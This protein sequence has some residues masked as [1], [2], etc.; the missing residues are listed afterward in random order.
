M[1]KLKELYKQTSDIIKYVPTYCDELRE[2]FRKCTELYM[3]LNT[4]ADLSDSNVA[5]ELDST[6]KKIAFASAEPNFDVRKEYLKEAITDL[7][8][9]RDTADVLC[10][11]DNILYVYKGGRL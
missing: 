6:I 5:K 11:F 8:S 3:L 2:E 10:K 1:D 4:V 9:G 7:A